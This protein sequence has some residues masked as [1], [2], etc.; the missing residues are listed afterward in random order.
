M[1]L[2]AQSILKQANEQAIQRQCLVLQNMFTAQRIVCIFRNTALNSDSSIFA[3]VSELNTDE[4][5]YNE[6][7]YQ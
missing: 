2:S 1:L 3:E 4:L 5:K 7:R 6:S